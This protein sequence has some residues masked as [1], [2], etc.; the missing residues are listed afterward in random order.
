MLIT[1]RAARSQMKATVCHQTK[2]TRIHMR[3]QV[4]S[5]AQQSSSQGKMAISELM[6]EPGKA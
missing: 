4:D 5:L 3:T 6:I 1:I 2:V